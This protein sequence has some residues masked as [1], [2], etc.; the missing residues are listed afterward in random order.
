MPAK[1]LSNGVILCECMRRLCIG[2]LCVNKDG[3]VSSPS[4]TE[5]VKAD[6]AC[7]AVAWWLAQS[8]YSIDDNCVDKDSVNT[9]TLEN[10]SPKTWKL[11]YS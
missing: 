10:Q 1:P 5:R 3:C 2:L 8:D 6:D 9:A 11:A 7:Q 4:V